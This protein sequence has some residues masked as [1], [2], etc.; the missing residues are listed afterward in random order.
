MSLQQFETRRIQPA[1]AVA[2]QPA[3]GV[4]DFIA[5]HLL[6][7]TCFGGEQQ[8]ADFIA[9]DRLVL[10]QCDDF[11]LLD[12][13]HQMKHAVAGGGAGMP[14]WPRID[15]AVHRRTDAGDAAAMQ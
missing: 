14:E 2:G 3:A 15:T 7:F 4:A 5:L 12:S 13:V 8:T 9:N 11:Q 10:L 6:P 1:R